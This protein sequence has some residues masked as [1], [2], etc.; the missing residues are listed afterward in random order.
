M[1]MIPVSD[2]SLSGDSLSSVFIIFFFR[3]WYVFIV[4]SFQFVCEGN[5]GQTKHFSL[6][7]QTCQ[8]LVKTLHFSFLTPWSIQ[9][10]NPGRRS[11]D[12]L[13]LVARQLFTGRGHRNDEQT[14]KGQFRVFPQKQS[15]NTAVISE[16]RFLLL[17]ICISHQ[18]QCD[19]SAPYLLSVTPGS[20][21]QTLTMQF[22]VLT[23]RRQKG[24]RET[25]GI[26]P[27][28]ASS[29]PRWE[30]V[31]LKARQGARLLLMTLF[32]MAALWGVISGPHL[33]VAER[34]RISV[35]VTFQSG[36]TGKKWR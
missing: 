15:V 19:V 18:T 11:G 14:T 3:C 7:L 22:C 5:V 24:T 21:F 32:I 1:M 25:W 10:W 16:R 26:K 9:W 12:V 20:I 4:I 30:R 13:L 8:V 6:A 35:N 29:T 28:S 2:W 31:V 27:P 33:H 34:Q 17:D 23:P 36:R